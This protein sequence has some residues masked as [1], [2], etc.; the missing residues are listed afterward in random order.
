MDYLFF[1]DDAR[2]PGFLLVRDYD[3]ECSRPTIIDALER[4]SGVM[5]RRG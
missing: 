4:E 2:R 3:A 1:C 5:I